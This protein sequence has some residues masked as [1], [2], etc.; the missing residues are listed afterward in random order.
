[1]RKFSSAK[2][3]K[4]LKKGI[5]KGRRV[6]YYSQAHSKRESAGEWVGRTLKTIQEEKEKE[7]K[8]YRQLISGVLNF[9]GYGSN[10]REEIEGL[11]TR[12]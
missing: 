10:Q 7:R 4:N 3:I 9:G 6:W 12:V 8:R 1:M 5:D 2:C 11:N